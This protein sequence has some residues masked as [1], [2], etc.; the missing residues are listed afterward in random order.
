M[1]EQNAPLALR[2]D[3]E[4][5][6]KLSSLLLICFDTLD[7]FGKE[8]EQ[9]ENI[10][11]AFKMFLS[12]LTIESIEGAF[13]EYMQ[14]NT[15]MPKPADIVKIATRP[16]YVGTACSLTDGQRRRLEELRERDKQSK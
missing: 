5:Q 6:K 15:V 16:V 12:G 7:T 14:G 2:D 10:N 3:L 4:G 8:P 11:L 1:S 9:L 13:M